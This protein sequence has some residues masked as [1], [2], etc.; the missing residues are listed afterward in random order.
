[1]AQQRWEQTCKRCGQTF[2]VGLWSHEH[3]YCSICTIELDEEIVDKSVGELLPT[4]EDWPDPNIS[5]TPESEDDGYRR[6]AKEDFD[7]TY[8]D[9]LNGLRPKHLDP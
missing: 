7:H 5:S 6:K 1:M 2:E 3:E 8:R 4:P 9:P